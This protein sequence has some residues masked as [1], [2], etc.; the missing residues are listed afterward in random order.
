M[1]KKGQFFL[2]AALIIVGLILSLGTVYNVARVQNEDTRVSDLSKEISFEGAKVIDSG[3]YS[4]KTTEETRGYLNSLIG[5][6]SSDVLKSQIIAVYGN[7]TN[8]VAIEFS[9]KNKGSV[10]L[11]GTNTNICLANSTNTITNLIN[12]RE[13][14]EI[15]INISGADQRF[16]LVDNQ[17]FYIIVTRDNAGER[18]VSRN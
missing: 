9:C 14:G 6:Y 11:G 16:N 4:G 3:V 12:E 18:Y 1:N 8:V 13:D 2:I 5:N 7:S 15:S 10:G 17:N